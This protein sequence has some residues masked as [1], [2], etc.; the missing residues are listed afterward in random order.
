M[1]HWEIV[2]AIVLFIAWRRGHAQQ[3]AAQQIN[4]ATPLDPYGSLTDTWGQL[5]GPGVYHPGPNDISVMY[6][7]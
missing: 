7:F 2:F 5:Q 1:K 6:S 3:Q 4:E